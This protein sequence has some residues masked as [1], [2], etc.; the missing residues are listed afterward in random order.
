MPP[1][2]LDDLSVQQSGRALATQRAGKLAGGLAEANG[3]WLR[4]IARLPLSLL[5][6]T[7]V[8]PIL[9]GKLR[10]Q[11]WIVGS[12]LHRCWLGYYESG[13]Q[14]Q[15][16]REVRPS[17]VFWD[18][19][20]NVG[21]YS[22]LASKLVGAGKVFAFEPA[23][24]NVCYLKKHLALNRVSNVEVLAIAVSDRN[25][26]AT[27]AAEQTG[28]MGRL[29]G[30]GS[31]A[32]STATLDSLVAEG[33]VL[34]PDYVKMDIEGAELLALHG[35]RETFQRF[36]PVLFLATHGLEIGKEC[37]RLLESWGY[38]CRSVMRTPNR[39]SGELVAKFREQKQTSDQS[40]GATASVFA[41][42]RGGAK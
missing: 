7:M 36:R 42:A 35:G 27:F 37:R 40:R 29:S 24:R 16:S 6:P 26:V 21:F 15:I 10:G 33:K 3:S 39:E 5:P 25:G 9:A 17:G 22:L 2:Q 12:G 13:M 18:I 14:R 8:V 23:P 20:A 19:G 4:R 30:E 28:F 32:V 38:E 1:F 11:R 41:K 31:L 34:P